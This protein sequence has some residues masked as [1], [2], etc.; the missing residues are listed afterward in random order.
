MTAYFWNEK[1]KRYQRTDGKFVNPDRLPDQSAQPAP[2]TGTEISHE[3]A[4]LLKALA[5]IDKKL[6]QQNKHQKIAAHNQSDLSIGIELT[7]QWVLAFLMF[8]Y[9]TVVKLVQDPIGTLTGTNLG[10]EIY[11]KEIQAGDTIGDFKVTSGFGDRLAPKDGASTY[12]EG[13]DL[14]TPIGIQLYM[15]GTAQGKVDCQ[16]SEKAGTYATITPVGIPFTFQAMHLGQCTSGEFEP[17]QAFAAT[18][19]SGNSTGE[20][21]HWGQ[22]RNGKAVNPTEGYLLWSLKGT[23]PSPVTDTAQTGLASATDLYSRII[24]QESGGNPT[25]VNP[26]TG[27]IGLGQV[28]PRNVPEWTQQCLGQS[29]TADQFAADAEAQ[30][31]TVNCKLQEYLR[32]AKA[33]GE[34]DFEGCRSVA[35]AWYSGDP[36]LKNSDSPQAGYPSIKAY[37]KSVCSGYDSKR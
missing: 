25:Q 27:A 30:K 4:L 36:M 20:H 32:A 9:P 6:A 23:P 16:K 21:L 7:I 37:T 17:G 12:H 5:S 19:N 26:D 10:A 13:I 2:Q 11:S 3:T 18:G 34:S 14:G 28:M 15:I 35:A 22:F 24:Q 1:A 33:R 29:L 31:K 8:C